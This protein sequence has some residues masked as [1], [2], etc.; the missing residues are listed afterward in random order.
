MS[1]CY[2]VV[3]V[4]AGLIGASMAFHASKRR[5]TVLL[6]QESSPGYHSSGRSA[7][8][9]LPPYGG[10]IARALTAASK[11]FL[12][13]PPSDF[14]EYPLTKSR[15]ALFIAGLG[16]AHLL[17]Q[18]TVA[19]GNGAPN[20]SDVSP[21]KA[22]QMVPI[23]RPEGI[24]GAV[25][26]HDV[27]DI[28][29]AALLQG[30]L[31]AFRANEGAIHLDS[32]VVS[33]AQ[34]AGEWIVNTRSGE[35]RG[36]VLVNAAGAWADS[37][38]G[39]AGIPAKGLVPTRRTMVVFK[40]PDSIDVSSWPLVADAGEKFYFKPDAG[41]LALS[42]ADCEVV[43]AGDIFPDDLD[44][45][46]GIDRFEAATTMT[47]RR[48]EH[49][50]AGLRTFTPDGEPIVGF[51][52]GAPNFVWAAGFGGFGVQACYGAGLC[53]EALLSARRLPAELSNLGLDLERLSPR[54]LAGA[55]P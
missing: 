35:F 5:R 3:V 13:N 37:V 28:D 7:A 49:Q 32:K 6:E 9:M 31:K 8:V 14:S 18:W 47:V 11:Q 50:W 23:L 40:G 55:G 17:N 15:G 4:G 12:L 41:R 21:E 1:I 22:V 16:Q 30:Y 19:S 42:P 44:V 53:C 43:P 10:P 33:I 25:L 2:D 27:V 46:V 29:A 24:A 52:P 39:L 26:L 34:A 36:K 48:V 54:R 45:A 51:D 38:A 20:I